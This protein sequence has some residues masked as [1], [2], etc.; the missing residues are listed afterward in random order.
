MN[1]WT[2]S[3]V[4]PWPREYPSRWRSESER[5]C[6]KNVLEGVTVGVNLEA[7]ASA[8]W[9]ARSGGRLDGSDSHSLMTAAAFFWFTILLVDNSLKKNVGLLTSKRF[10][11]NLILKNKRKESSRLSKNVLVLQFF[12]KVRLDLQYF[13]KRQFKYNTS[14]HFN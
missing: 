9:T 10:L 11:D 6:W 12:F 5:L 14:T 13:Y 3:G 7:P 1:T 8:L 4:L 2:D